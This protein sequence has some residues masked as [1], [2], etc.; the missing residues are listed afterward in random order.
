M[1]Q[2]FIHI[3]PHKTGTTTIQNSLIINRD[4][5]FRNGYLVPRAGSLM[6]QTGHHNLA[7][8]LLGSRKFKRSFG[9]WKSLLREIN[10]NDPQ[11]IILSAEAFS[12]LENDGILRLRKILSDFKVFIVFYARRQDK[13]IQSHWSEGIKS[14]T[15]L[16]KNDT[17]L[18]WIR[19]NN[20]QYRNSDYYELYQRWK[21]VFGN[22]ILIRVLEKGQL[23]GTLFQDF[24]LTIGEDN[25]R[26]YETPKD[27]N[28]SPGTKTLIM[29]Q[30]YKNVL[31]DKINSKTMAHLFA[32]INNFADLQGWNQ[33]KL[34]FATREIFDRI[35][36]HY[37][38]S[39]RKLALEYFNRE[40]LFFEP[41]EESATNLSINDFPS[42]ELI[43]LNA[44]LIQNINF[45]ETTSDNVASWFKKNELFQ[46]SRKLLNR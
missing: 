31:K 15:T 37:E 40:Q 44:H 5:L 10:K 38:E 23:Q 27:K 11:K 17:F 42:N 32:E 35:M 19:E 46:K 12:R 2:I 43:K 25:P 34:N 9:T 8:E 3:G 16:K 22:N 7:W 4:S 21:N 28:V 39:N 29:M 26:Q 13:K 41:F 18:N 1:R 14:P 6:D 45:K 24:M 20:Y 36:S 30:A 33:Q